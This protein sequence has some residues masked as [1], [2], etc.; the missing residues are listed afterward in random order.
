[1][2]S[3]ADLRAGLRWPLG[4]AVAVSAGLLGAMLALSYADA[5]FFIYPLDDPYIHLAVAKNFRLTGIPGINPGVFAH[6]T[7]SML[8]PA[9]LCVAPGFVGLPMVWGAI[10]ALLILYI[11]EQILHAA[12]I[13]ARARALLLVSLAGVSTLPVQVFSG[14]EHTLHAFVALAIVAYAWRLLRGDGPGEG[15]GVRGLLGL[16]GLLA[17]GF[18]ARPETVFLAFPLGLILAWRRGFFAA[19]WVLALSLLPMV[20]LGLLSVANG[21]QYLPN[22]VLLKG[23]TLIVFGELGSVSAWATAAQLLWAKMREAWVLSL[24]WGANLALLIVFFGREKRALKSPVIFS[25]GAGRATFWSVLFLVTAVGHLFAAGVGWLYRYEFYLICLGAIALALMVQQAWEQWDGG[26]LAQRYWHAGNQLQ[27]LICLGLAA[28]ALA[29]VGFRTLD[30]TAFAL[31]GAERRAREQALFTEFLNHYY[32]D[33]V[34]GL[35]DVGMPSYYGHFE[36]VDLY[37]L[38]DNE[39][40]E[41]KLAPI[42]YPQFYRDFAQRRGV[43]IILVFESWFEDKIPPEWIYVGSWGR[44]NN[45]YWGEVVLFYARTPE[46]ARAL[47]KNMREFRRQMPAEVRT[48]LAGEPLR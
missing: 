16:S 4:L 41:A 20:L 11:S 27:R 13:P 21:A 30:T 5:S 31:S 6:A 14:M 38:G 17:I 37:G 34:V 36:V 33:A 12:G 9:L 2:R 15:G 32:Q 28:M 19:A 10:F 23:N 48:E 7:S 25:Q 8:W 3:F 40:T 46:D 18:L 1:M 44:G 42:D 29:V 26:A 39:V 47:Q 45:V 22:P 35:N 24:L 43:D